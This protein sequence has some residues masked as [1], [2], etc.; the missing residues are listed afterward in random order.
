MTPTKGFDELRRGLLATPEGRTASDR[1]REDVSLALALSDL[2]A[3]RSVTQ[4]EMA[5]SLGVS[6]PNVSRVEHEDD[7]HLSTLRGYVRALGGQLEVRAVFDDETVILEAV[8]TEPTDA[9]SR[10]PQ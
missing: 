4:V 3:R 1:A 8:S 2:R 5:E 6:Q 7:V 9:S 10:R